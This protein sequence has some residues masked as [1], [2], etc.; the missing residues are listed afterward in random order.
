MSER[1]YVFDNA[2]EGCSNNG[3]M[4]LIGNLCNKQNL[5]P[6]LLMSV[7]NNRGNGFGDGAF[8]WFWIVIL[9]I[10]GWGGF[11]GGYG[12][13]GGRGNA[14]GFADLGNLVNND[15]GRELLMQAI[16]GNANAIGQLSTKLGCDYNALSGAIQSLST[17]I[18]GLGNTL[19]LGQRDIIQAMQ[20]GNQAILSKLCDCCCQ[21]QRQIADFKGDLSLQM[22]QQTNTLSNGQRDLGVAVTKGFCDTAYATRE[23]TCEILNAIDKQTQVIN[24]KFSQ[25]EFREM[26]RENQALRDQL[27][28]CRLSDSQNAQTAQIVAQL[29]PVPRP[30]YIVGNPYQSVYPYGYGYGYPYGYPYGYNSNGCGCG[31]GCGNNC[32]GCCNG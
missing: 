20:N 29:Q 7:M 12:N 27:Q 3:L 14:Q 24:E 31:N 23:Q 32:G 1:T 30:S 10:F 16:N 11:G 6:A 13:F 18:C 4:S 17:Q 2:G 25:A 22:C 19:G 15:A 9:M 8:G 26:T 21:T 5:D 28:A